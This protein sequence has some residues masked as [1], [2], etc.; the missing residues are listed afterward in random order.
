MDSLKAV[1]YKQQVIVNEQHGEAQRQD[2]A[3]GRKT[4]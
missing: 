4:F 2:K 1:V 3:T